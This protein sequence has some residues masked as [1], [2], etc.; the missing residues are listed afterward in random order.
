MIN[1]S[2]IF[3]K[4]IL[5]KYFLDKYDIQDFLSIYFKFYCLIVFVNT[6]HYNDKIEPAPS[7]CEIH[8]ESKSKPLD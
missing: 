8:F 3:T 6:Y 5:I 7:I 4:E 2:S 1:I